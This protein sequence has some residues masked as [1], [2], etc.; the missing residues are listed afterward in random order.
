MA[1]CI[2]VAWRLSP[3][4]SGHWLR[5]PVGRDQV[6]QIIAAASVERPQVR[7]VRASQGRMPVN[8]RWR[9]LQG[10]CNRNV[11]LLGIIVRVEGQC[12]GLPSGWQQPGHM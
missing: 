6:G 11:P 4:L 10:K 9:R 3:V 8:G 12:K 1:I 7:K 5:I 2:R